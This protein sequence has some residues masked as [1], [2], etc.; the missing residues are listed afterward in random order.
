MS[1]QTFP[2]GWAIRPDTVIRGY[3]SFCVGDTR[4]TCGERDGKRHTTIT[5]P[6]RGGSMEIEA[7]ECE[8]IRAILDALWWLAPTVCNDW[9]TDGFRPAAIPEDKP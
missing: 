9:Y 7:D 8:K 3:A 1:E 4:L 6:E 2:S 5:G